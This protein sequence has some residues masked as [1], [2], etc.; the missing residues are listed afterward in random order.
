MRNDAGKAGN[1]FIVQRGVKVLVA[2]SVHL[3]PS[4]K[5]MQNRGSGA[6]PSASQAPPPGELPTVPLTAVICQLEFGL[7]LQADPELLQA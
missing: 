5:L 3:S 2:S 6:L 4:V 1:W 7:R